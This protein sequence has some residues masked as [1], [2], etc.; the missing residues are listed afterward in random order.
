MGFPILID[1]AVRDL[2]AAVAIATAARE[3]GAAG[4]RVRDAAGERAAL[5][6]SVVASYLA[7]I[8]DGIGYLVDLPT[9]GN[10]PYNAARRILSFDRATGGRS[11]VVLRTGSGDEVSRATAPDPAATDPVRRW[12]EYATVLTRLWESF[13][14]EALIADQE[15]AR[16]VDPAL[17][18]AIDYEGRYYRV[19]GPL[20]GPSSVQ[21]RPVLAVAD[22]GELGWDVV[23]GSADVVVVERDRSAEAN[24]ALV[25]ALA[26][27]DRERADIALL[28]VVS[29]APLA[30]VEA[31]AVADDLSAWV[32]ADALNGLT[33]APTG[34]PDEIVATIHALVPLLASR[35]AGPTLR[36]GLGLRTFVGA[37]R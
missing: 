34:N 25:A 35:P 20:D 5:D 30:A 26:T 31:R 3:A 29:V 15:R 6:P 32:T 2:G 27:T 16:V 7:G 28:G 19:A 18:S 14:R 11:G 33:L 13:P 12:A 1:I 23:A 24:T 17:I 9:T 10:A 8:A 37:A 21:G 4:V 22:P 36:E